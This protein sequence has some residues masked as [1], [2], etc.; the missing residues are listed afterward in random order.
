[1]LLEQS[2]G[3]GSVV[4]ISSKAVYVDDCG[5][6]S[7][8]DEPPVFGGPVSE[9]QTTIAPSDLNYRSREGYGANKVAAEQVLLDS[10]VAV[11]VLRPSRIHG[12]GAARPREWVFV[13]RVLDGRRHV[14]LARYG[15]GINHPTAAVNLAALVRI[16]AESPGTRILNCA[17]PD[18]PDGLAICRAISGYLTHEWEEILL[19]DTAPEGLGDHPWNTWPP[20]ILATK[21][22]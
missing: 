12:V 6:H 10:G 3:I 17:D 8:S 2:A 14:F 11:S 20:F 5:R 21:V 22:R 13:K 15:R 7:N 19:D 1:M 4:F 16:C 9:N 18:A